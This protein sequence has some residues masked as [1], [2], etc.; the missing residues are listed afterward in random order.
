MNRVRG[1]FYKSSFFEKW[2]NYPLLLHVHTEGGSPWLL[3]KIEN[4][5][6]SKEQLEWSRDC[7]QPFPL[8]FYLNKI[9]LVSKETYKGEEG[10]RSVWVSSWK[11]KDCLGEDAI[12]RDILLLRRSTLDIIK[13][14]K[15][16]LEYLGNFERSPNTSSIFS[17]IIGWAFCANTLIIWRH[18]TRITLK[19]KWLESVFVQNSI[20]YNF[21]TMI[22]T[23]ERD[24]PNLNGMY[25][26][27][28]LHIS[29]RHIE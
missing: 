29:L 13:H 20:C 21:P 27:S 6:L 19:E 16:T 3:Q 2:N 11:R 4:S 12:S 25:N 24:L 5:G 15:Y 7:Q 26:K 18:V 23:Y 10:L 14:L 9:F 17:V 22:K 1:S 8:F 28:I